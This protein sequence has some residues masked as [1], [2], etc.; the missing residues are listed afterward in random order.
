M[1]VTDADALTGRADSAG[2]Y[3]L[4]TSASGSF[5]HQWW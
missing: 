5:A 2:D 1:T 3:S 4:R